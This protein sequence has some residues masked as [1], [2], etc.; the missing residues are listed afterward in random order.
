MMVHMDQ[1]SDLQVFLQVGLK[2]LPT[3]LI[4]IVMHLD[5]V[6]QQSEWPLFDSL[7]KQHMHGPT[8]VLLTLL[9]FVQ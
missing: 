8:F 6:R 3:V 4:T 1:A 9:W 7:P 5:L 2:Q